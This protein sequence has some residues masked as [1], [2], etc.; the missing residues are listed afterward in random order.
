[1]AEYLLRERLGTDSDWEVCSAGVLASHGAPASIGS[2][3]ALKERGIDMVSHRS[4]PV[5]GELV[6]A[7]SLIVVMTI[8][9]REQIRALFPEVMEKVFLLKSFSSDAA[10]R[11]IEDPMGLSADIYRG[12][13]DE[14]DTTL[15]GLIEFMEHMS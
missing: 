9:H 1:M 5:D 13:R 10:D 11:E 12:I 4:R 7:S 8:S 3:Q 2:V 14:I 6:D 15:P